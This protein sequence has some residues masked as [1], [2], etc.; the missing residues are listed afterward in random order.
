[1][2]SKE[3][4]S[5]PE[6]GALAPQKV[7]NRDAQLKDYWYRGLFHAL[8][9]SAL[10]DDFIDADPHTQSSIWDKGDS[11]DV[12]RSQLKR[13]VAMIGSEHIVALGQ[14]QSLR[15]FI[16]H[17]HQYPN[18]SLGAGAHMGVSFGQPPTWSTAWPEEHPAGSWHT[19]DPLSSQS[20]VVAQ[21]ASA[22]IQIDGLQQTLD[23]LTD[24]VQALEKMVNES[25][26]V[27]MTMS[28]SYYWTSEWQAKEDRADKDARLGRSQIYES[29]DELITDLNK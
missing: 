12:S 7:T 18:I 29:V 27:L 2:V 1:M 9:N 6:M 20:P 5:K 28:Q 14:D 16:A 17:S 21:L 23:H 10:D 11:R 19:T 3:R 8:A 25:H 13:I 15:N 24:K 26:K 4:A 22:R